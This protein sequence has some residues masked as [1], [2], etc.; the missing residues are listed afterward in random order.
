MS[1][2]LSKTTTYN[3]VVNPATGKDIQVGIRTDLT[4]DYIASGVYQGSG[5]SA[6]HAIGNDFDSVVKEHGIG[7]YKRMLSD[8]E[9]SAAISA[10]VEASCSTAL[11]VRPLISDP[12]H[13]EYAVSEKISEFCRWAI[14][15]IPDL[16]A[17]QKAQVQDGLTFGTSVSSLSFEY[18]KGPQ[19][20]GALTI[21]RIKPNPLESTNFVIDSH[22]NIIGIIPITPTDPRFLVGNSAM[23]VGESSI[24]KG[25][26]PRSSFAIL[27]WNPDSGD[28]RGQSLLR[29]AFNAWWIKQKTIESMMQWQQRFAWPSIVGKLPE[30]A[31]DICII[32]E[33]TGEEISRTSATE[34]LIE[35]LKGFS[36]GS[37]LALPHGAMVELL[38]VNGSANV[39]LDIIAWCNTEIVRS[40]QNQHLATAEG[41]HQA[42]AAADVHKD[43]L[44]LMISSI[45]DW[46]CSM[47]R[48]DVLK[49]LVESNYPAF[50]HLVPN[51]D[52]GD[53][54]GFRLTVADVASLAAV[55]W[56]SDGQKKE[57]DR[58]LGLPQR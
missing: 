18:H 22:S 7:I 58:Q 40:I 19:Y 28:P 23:Y 48:N 9:V 21:S 29:P 45:K 52:L 24:V 12:E 53:G 31:E 51:V 47:I 33:V 3:N 46:Y 54:T 15:R 1:Q 27:T 11:N 39:F 43:V 32:D 8:G 34:A 44:S 2:N 30:F 41:I 6:L 14:N 5:M 42:R 25:M 17:S 55:G 10:F 36:N 4:R 20:N 38:Q 16:R 13:E 56:F 37:I 26:L 50:P 35:A 49:P 57:I